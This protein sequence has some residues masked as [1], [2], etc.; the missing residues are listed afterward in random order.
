MSAFRYIPILLSFA[1]AIPLQVM[2]GSVDIAAYEGGRYPAIVVKY[3]GVSEARARPAASASAQ[4]IENIVDLKAEG[5]EVKKLFQNSRSSRAATSSGAQDANGLQRYYSLDLPEERQGDARYINALMERI[6]N[7]SQVELVYPASDPVPL[8]EDKNNSYDNTETPSRS[9]VSRAG[10][11]VAIPDFTDL[12]GY[13]KS[14]LAFSGNKLGGI[15]WHDVRSLAGAQGEGITIVSAETSHWD[16]N[17]PDLPASYR[18]FG[19]T[20]RVGYH[21]TGS[22]GVMGG[23]DNGYGIIGIAN[24]AR[25]GHVFA[26]HYDKSL[27]S[28]IEVGEDL[29]PGDVIQVG[30]QVNAPGALEISHCYGGK[31]SNCLVPMEFQPAWYDAIKSLTDKGIIVIQA[32]GNGDVDLDSPYFD[33]K[34]DKSNRDSGAIIVGAICAS[35]GGERAAF[36]TYGARVSSSSWGCSEV[37][38]T[39]YGG[40]AANLHTS[41]E[42]TRTYGGTSSANPIVAGA[43]ASLSGYAKSKGIILAPREVRDI[44]EST[45]TQLPNPKKRVGTQ[46]DLVKA[47]RFFDE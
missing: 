14:P 17:H 39:T 27:P 3:K 25:F 1:A 4:T 46:P 15:N 33:G 19:G 16:T 12:Q 21:D 35:R 36:S 38:T 40:V 42:Y 41:P 45:G 10:S 8:S 43:A 2:A 5:I 32:A 13:L 11:E 44:L 30:M 6:A 37:V 31:S 7:L 26:R 23:K 22:V 24:R 9:W 29:A 28:L 47:F 20:I 18:D 34:F